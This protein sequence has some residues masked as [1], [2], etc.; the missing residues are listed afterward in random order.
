VGG[1]RTEF[2]FDPLGREVQMTVTAEGEATRETFSDYWP[3]GELRS[4]RTE[5]ASSA[6]DTVERWFRFSDGRLSRLDRKRQGAAE[7]AKH[8]AYDYDLN[9]NRVEDERGTHGFNSR[10]QLVR[11]TKSGGGQVDYALNGSGSVTSRSD[12]TATTTYHYLPGGERLDHAITTQGGASSRTDY[13]YAQGF[14]DITSYRVEGASEPAA[15]FSYDAFGR[16]TRS[17][18]GADEELYSYDGL[19]RRD[20]K[21]AGGREFDLSYI[22]LSEALSQEQ[23]FGGDER[24][25]YDYNSAMERLGTAR[26]TSPTQT[27]PYRAYSTDASGSVEGLEDANGEIV[28]QR[29][30]YDPYGAQLSAESGLSGE[31]QANPFRFQ[32]HY[33]DPA[34]QTYDMRA[35]A[36]LPELGRFLQEDHYEEA[37]GDF[38]LES[39]PLT[40]DRYAFLG[41]NPVN[42]IEF[43][44]HE[45]AHGSFTNNPDRDNR[46]GGRADRNLNRDYNFERSDTNQLTV[47][48]RH[49]TPR[50]G[51]FHSSRTVFTGRN[52][53][54]TF[55]P[56]AGRAGA[57]SVDPRHMRDEE[58]ERINT[59]AGI[60]PG[61]YGC[62]C[63]VLRSQS[64]PE[65][66]ASIIFLL[67][68]PEALA[69]RGIAAAGAAAARRFGPRIADWAGDLRA[70]IGP[71]L[72]DETG[73]IPA[74][75]A[76]IRLPAFTQSSIDEA[77]SSSTRLGKGGQI[78]EGA[79]AIAKKQGQG[80]S[81]FEGLPQSQSQAEAIIRDILR[82][83]TVV[84]RGDRVID[85]YNAAGQGVRLRRDTRA[86]QGF[87]DIARRPP[88]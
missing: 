43:D 74:T 42:L 56:D 15:E 46:Y 66:A 52:P 26:R 75:K 47:T 67:A 3:G 39:D 78:Q 62:A 50:G 73:S 85:A 82:N 5:R 12:G 86:F 64:H 10:D 87:L 29:Y 4:R 61:S 37:A 36:Y 7:F 24:R 20:T 58:G 41:G 70:T 63:I 2:C 53:R 11:W 45:P 34:Q 88:R 31:A 79:R 30:S 77:V 22:G 33:Y 19:D 51:S 35:R 14:G 28:G 23:Q 25:S 68:G 60:T 16:L 84:D 32:G 9:G 59:G 57:K 40:Q 80:A 38:R 76:P 21:Q 8:Q 54:V 17:K 44:G 48:T 55:A 1:K 69:T 13:S 65:Q 27:A 18:R 81:P 49:T 72:A 71:R 6:N 83:P